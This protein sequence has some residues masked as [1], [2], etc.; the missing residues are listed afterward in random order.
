MLRSMTDLEGY[1]IGAIN[2]T[3]GH[4]EDF[5]FDDEAWVIRYLVVDTG[6]WL[7]S[8]RVLISPVA[9]GQPNWADKL[10][11]VAITTEQVKNSPD[12]DTQKPV[13]RHQESQYLE[14]Y[15]YP[16]YWLG[17]AVW[18]Q[19]AYPNMALPGVASATGNRQVQAEHVLTDAEARLTQNDDPHLRSCKEVMDFHIHA[20]DGDIGHV[21]GMLIDDENWRVRYLVVATSNWWFGHQ[22]LIAPQWIHDVSWPDAKVSV[23]LTRQ[24]VQ[25]APPYEPAAQLDRA[26]EAGIYKHYGRAGYWA[27]ELI[28]ESA[29]SRQ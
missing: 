8:R 28:R 23:N 4:V 5:Y 18:G 3:I 15:G 16:Y 21:Q 9:I 14:Y 22:V 27:D 24:A 12:I 10:L 17:D 19:G 7:L 11:P 25:D 2:G 1:A 26:R 20:T 6:A 29:V 13:S